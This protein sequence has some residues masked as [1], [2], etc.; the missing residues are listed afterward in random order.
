[1]DQ[2]PNA[3]EELRERSV[4]ALGHPHY[5]ALS[6]SLQANEGEGQNQHG[7]EETV[8]SSGDHDVEER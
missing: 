4:F 1:M 5:H 2:R 6:S 7:H 3:A 8:S